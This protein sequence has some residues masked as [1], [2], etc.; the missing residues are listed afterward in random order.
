MVAREGW[1]AAEEGEAPLAFLVRGQTGESP[2]VGVEGARLFGVRTPSVET[3]C[4][5]EG[6]LSCPLDAAL[7]GAAAAAHG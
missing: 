5:G 2:A 3:D 7:S 1:T 6:L 4:C